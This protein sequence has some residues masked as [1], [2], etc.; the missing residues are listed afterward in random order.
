VRSL[1]DVMRAL[2]QRHGL[3]GTG[4]PEDGVERVTAEVTG[5]DLKPEFDA[6]VRG[7]QVLPLEKLLATHG[8]E[9][10][11]RGAES[12]DDKG[13][14][15]GKASG[16]SRA[17]FGA[18]TRSEGKDVLV[19]HVL[20]GGAAQEAGLAAGDVIVAIDGLRAG[21]AGLERALTSRKPGAVLKVHAFRRDE[22][23]QFDV[24]LKRAPQ[25]TCV[26][27]EAKQGA[28]GR[29]WAGKWLAPTKRT[30]RARHS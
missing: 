28:A 5:L 6:W 7:T 14:K 20:E 22:L 30:D 8:I 4:V 9:M 11:L 23:M 19:T 12:A 16:T 1:D 18:R 15:A 24:R 29:A 10:T 2:W 13:G 3:T 21:S 17:S 26:L 27:G 25:D